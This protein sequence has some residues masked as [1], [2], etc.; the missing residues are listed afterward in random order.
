MPWRRRELPGDHRVRGRRR[1]ATPTSRVREAGG[2]RVR[3]MGG[4]ARALGPPG[5]RWASAFLTLLADGRTHAQASKAVE[6]HRSTAY[7]LKGRD[8]AFAA[9]YADARRA[10]GEM[11]VEEAIRR[12]RDGVP[13]LKFYKGEPI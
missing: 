10:G 5:P 13:H 2:H 3:A 4:E 1:A 12:A 9:A 11:L 7:D 6:I 8:K